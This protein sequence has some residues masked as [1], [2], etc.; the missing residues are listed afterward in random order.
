MTKSHDTNIALI[1][2]VGFE[3]V[4][5]VAFEMFQIALPAM[6]LQCNLTKSSIHLTIGAW[7]VMK[8]IITIL[9]VGL[10]SIFGSKKIILYSGSLYIAYCI[11]LILF[12]SKYIVLAFDLVQPLI[13]TAGGILGVA[14]I[15]RT[16]KNNF[17]ATKSL[18]W[19]PIILGS[20]GVLSPV[21]G[22]AMVEY[23]HWQYIFIL[24]ILLM[25]FIMVAV[26]YY[27][28][29]E[30][31]LPVS[32]NVFDILSNVLSRY[33]D[34]ARSKIFL[35]YSAIN[36][37]L[38]VI[39]IAWLVSAPIL[40]TQVYSYGVLQLGILTSIMISGYMV[41]AII[42][43]IILRDNNRDLVLQLGVYIC[44]FGTLLAVAIS[45]FSGA[46]E[47]FIIALCIC[48][49][50][51]GMICMIMQRIIVAACSATENFVVSGFW[52]F[53]YIFAAIIC[54]FAD[55]FYNIMV[56]AGVGC[57]A[58]LLAVIILRWQ[59]GSIVATSA[60]MEHELC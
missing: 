50:G 9:L 3:A 56:F 10:S 25:A 39:I 34:I 13:M 33:R 48:N 41:G 11:W 47:T 57:G 29:K 35:K 17:Q 28:P 49:I 58:A 6:M 19:F 8:T 2:I 21:I 12:P 44:L 45:I 4:S 38:S 46:L 40:V 26:F 59:P 1:A 36:F 55:S 14:L 42:S 30:S 31:N 7:F 23:L 54:Y 32:Y 20:V 18:L 60:V 27:L 15:H 24:T 16:I 43:K 5:I 37:L 51:R 52:I 22:G 53:Y